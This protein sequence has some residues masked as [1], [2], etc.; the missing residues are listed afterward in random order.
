MI[1][2]IARHTLQFIFLVLLQALVIDHVDLAH[3]WVVPYLYVLFIISLP[4]DTPPWATLLLGFALGMAMDFFSST[5]GMHASACTVMAFARIWMLRLLEPRDGYDTGKRPVV[6]HMGIRWYMAFAGTL[7]VVHHLWLFVVE[8]YRFDDFPT[9]FVR[10]LMSAAAT[11]VLCLLAQA[12]TVRS[13]PA[14]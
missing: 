10:A 13:S 6:Q 9:T 1:G 12:L 2:R 3:G 5:P 8:V 4:F 14:R 7:V 11:L